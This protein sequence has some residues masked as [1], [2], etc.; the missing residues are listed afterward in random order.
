MSI[1]A[2]GIYYG[3][4]VQGAK[5]TAVVTTTGLRT[6]DEGGL[7]DFKSGMVPVDLSIKDG[8]W[9]KSDYSEAAGIIK[10]TW[11][12]APLFLSPGLITPL[13]QQ[14]CAETTG[15]SNSIYKL[16]I[17]GSNPIATTYWTLV[18]HNTLATAKDKRMTDCV[19]K[20]IKLS[21]SESSNLCKMD[22]DFLASALNYGYTPTTDVFTMPTGVPLL[23]KGM[24]FK[25]GASATQ[26]PEYDITLDFGVQAICDNSGTP[27]EFIVGKFDATGTV[28]IP[29]VDDDVLA[30]FVTSV[31]NTLTWSWGTTGTSGFLE[32]II[33]VKYT[34]PDEDVDNEIR[35]RQSMPFKYAQ[36][37]AAELQISLKA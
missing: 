34:E 22:V 8:R 25:I 10:P 9:G 35:L 21:S 11:P 15:G 16:G 23:H 4:G 12:G 37:A 31:G 2:R 18:R 26:C 32:I 14:V 29:W 7:S 3:Y 17:T 28:R 30:D 24:T 1:S 6:R 5:G 20:S 13:L 33:P 27:Q 36:T 19:V